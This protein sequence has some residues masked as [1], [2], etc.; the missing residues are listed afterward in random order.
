MKSFVSRTILL[1]DVIATLRRLEALAW[2]RAPAASRTS[3][4]VG[5][6]GP[7][8]PPGLPVEDG[9]QHDQA[10]GHHDEPE[11]PGRRCLDRRD[12]AVE[13][14]KQT[15]KRHPVVYDRRSAKKDH[16]RDQDQNSYRGRDRR[17]DPVVIDELLLV[18]PDLALQP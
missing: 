6:M 1:W 5:I 11:Q 4:T 15:A 7:A 9:E 12:Q 14:Y 18:G 10:Y 17:G 8:G 3:G 2:H 16:T 13:Q